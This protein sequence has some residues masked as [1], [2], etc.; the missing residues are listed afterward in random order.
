MYY[1][2]L[3]YSE[4]HADL[5]LV[6]WF[7]VN[8]YGIEFQHFNIFWKPLWTMG[9]FPEFCKHWM[10]W[11][12][13]MKCVY[14]CVNSICTHLHTSVVVVVYLSCRGRRKSWSWRTFVRRTTP[15]TAA[16]LLLGTSVAF[17]TETLSSNSPTR[18]VSLQTHQ[19]DRI[20]VFNF[21]I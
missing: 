13:F 6:S 5:F 19:Q 14:Y 3:F 8:V 16:S 1:D 12:Y 11:R 7:T 4:L 2:D 15:T 9:K 10:K 20:D 17:P 18:Q 21:T